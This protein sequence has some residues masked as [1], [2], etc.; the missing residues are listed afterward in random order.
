MVEV[1][2]V[3]RVMLWK[4]QSDRLCAERGKGGK[5]ME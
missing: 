5:V 1:M 2:I 4:G 3:V